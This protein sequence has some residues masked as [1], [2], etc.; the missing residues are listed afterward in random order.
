M[1]PGFFHHQLSFLLPLP[2]NCK[3][4][5]GCFQLS[6]RKL[7]GPA[8]VTR[9][10]VRHSGPHSSWRPGQPRQTWSD[11]YRESMEC[12]VRL[13]HP[14][15]LCEGPGLG[16]AGNSLTIKLAVRVLCCLRSTKTATFWG[17][18]HSPLGHSVVPKSGGGGS[19]RA[20]MR[21]RGSRVYMR[22]R[23]FWACVRF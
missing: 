17:W 22:G 13:N 9:Y 21:G 2:S 10:Q 12:S 1:S 5:H 14:V 7:G 15:H 16:P 8:R 23:D 3:A 18:Q 4:H 19:S 20:C 6:S 11:R